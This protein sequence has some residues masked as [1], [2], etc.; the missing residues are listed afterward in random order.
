MNG[1]IYRTEDGRCK[2]FSVENSK[3]FCTSTIGCEY[4][5]PSNSDAL[6]ALDNSEFAF[7]MYCVQLD[8]AMCVLQS[9]PTSRFPRTADGWS[10]GLEKEFGGFW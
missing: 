5:V 1:C 4:K 10:E 7:F 8:I 2:K 9:E 3:S 6:R